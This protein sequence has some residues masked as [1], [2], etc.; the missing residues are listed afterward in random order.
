MYVPPNAVRRSII[1][2]YERNNYN[3]MVHSLRTKH[4][5]NMYNVAWF[6]KLNIMLITDHTLCTKK[7]SRLLTIRNY[8][9]I[10]FRTKTLL[11]LE[12]K[13]CLQGHEVFPL[14]VEAIRFIFTCGDIFF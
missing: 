12:N 7:H 9:H 3:N 6:K 14:R 13:K 4:F 5:Y 10:Q 1:K 8:F 2:R 11:D